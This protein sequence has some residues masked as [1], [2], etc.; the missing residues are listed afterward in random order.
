MRVRACLGQ[1]WPEY[2]MEAWGLGLFMLTAG[3]ATVAL[4]AAASPLHGL[5]AD[6][7]TRRALI[8]AAMG[9]TAVGLIYSPWG[10][11]SGAHLNP[12]VTLAFLW[13]GRIARCDAVFYILAQFIGGTLGV[14]LTF[15]LFGAAF[16]HAPVSYIA[17]LPGE[18]GAGAAFAAEAL[19]SF[20]LMAM[21]LA[22]VRRPRLAP[23][24]GLAAGLLIALYIFFEAPLSGMSMNPARSFA[25]AAPSGLWHDAW[26]YYSAPFAG[27]IAAAALHRRRADARACAKLYHARDRRCIHCGYQP[28]AFTRTQPRH[29]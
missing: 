7:A 9:L 24:T 16:S 8:G 18:G 20:G 28:P 11:Q 17:T 6:P 23:Y 13:L 26:I 14:L 3:A 19:I 1:H 12:A 27:M 15:V 29:D 5:V 4:E 2:L 22:F 10:R 25:S 21:V